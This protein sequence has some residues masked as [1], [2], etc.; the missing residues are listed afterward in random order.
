MNNESEIC[1]VVIL[2]L[3][4]RY[5]FLTSY[6]TCLQCY[7]DWNK[8]AKVDIETMQLTSL[9]LFLSFIISYAF[10]VYHIIIKNFNTSTIYNI[11]TELFFSESWH[12]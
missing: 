1:I 9:K 7:Y 3:Y 11:C 2:W 5:I 10:V 8:F 12:Y 4:W 6:N